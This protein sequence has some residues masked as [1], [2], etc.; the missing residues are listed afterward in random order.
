MSTDARAGLARD[1]LSGLDDEM[2]AWQEE[3]YVHLHKNPELSMQEHETADEIHKRLESYGYEVQRFAGTGV[4]GVLKNGEGP[5][6]LYR[7]DI[8]ALPVQEDTGFPYASERPG[9]MHACGHDFHITAGL[10]AAY[11]LAERKDAWAGT[12]IALFQPAEETAAGAQAMVDD[13][14]VDRIPRP[15]VAL[16]AHVLTTPRSGEV[17]WVKGPILS[18]AA[19]LKITVYGK[20]S[21]GS[22]PHL[23]IDPVVLA[24]SIVTRLQGIVAREVS[25]FN[26]AV[27]TVGSLNTG[28]KA[29][30]IPATAEMQLNI[31]AYDLEVRDQ[32]IAAIERIVKAECE[33]S[34][35]PREPDIEVFDFFPLTNND[36]E[37]TDKV[38]E[39]FTEYFG[40]D[41]VINIDPQTASEDFSNVPDAFGTPYCYWGVGG[42]AA[43]EPTYPNHNPKFGPVMQ[44]TLRTGTEAAV[45]AALAYLGKA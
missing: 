7:A 45:T 28:T 8:D 37:V 36:A 41:R 21:H 10:G 29:N 20:G 27:V 13:G 4:V 3:L 38:V 22:M 25:P 14:L 1:V 44:P 35:S 31:R 30:I 43:G 34:G 11:L 26:F 5:A 19:S 42:F 15:D 32:L 39:A 12:Y 33:A 6:V 40:E 24:A 16:G 17:G 23:G 18:T 2:T 9:L